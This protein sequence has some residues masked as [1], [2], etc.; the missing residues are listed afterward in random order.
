MVAIVGTDA[1]AEG[2][3][4]QIA[5]TVINIDL[6]FNQAIYNQRIGRVRRAGSNH[7]TAF[8]YNLLTKDSIDINLY[9]KI[10]ET[11]NAFD[12]FVSVNKAQSDLLKRLSS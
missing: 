5:N 7:N 12:S 8:V 9:N 11:Q 4:L 1:M 3:N 6:P 2:L 10:K